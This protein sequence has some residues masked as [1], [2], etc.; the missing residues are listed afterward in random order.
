MTVLGTGLAVTVYSSVVGLKLRQTLSAPKTSQSYDKCMSSYFESGV[1]AYLKYIFN[2]CVSQKNSK[3]N[4]LGRKK[5]TV[6][7]GV[8]TEFLKIRVGLGR[9]S[10]QGAGGIEI[11]RSLL[12]V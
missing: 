3:I 4:A 1:Q 12:K 9:R 11:Y 5:N 6:S 8:S 2:V 7:W 10:I